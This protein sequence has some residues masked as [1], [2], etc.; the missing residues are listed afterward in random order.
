MQIRPPRRDRSGRESTRERIVAEYGKGAS[1]FSDPLSLGALLGIDPGE[2]R[3]VLEE[4]VA[5]GFLLRHE[6]GDA[7]IYYRDNEAATAEE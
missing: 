2:C 7:T 3:A 4:L 1:V 5:E 6:M